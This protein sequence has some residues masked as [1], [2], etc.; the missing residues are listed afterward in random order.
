MIHA[1]AKAAKSIKSVV[2]CS[3]ENAMT[4]VFTNYFTY[5]VT[6]NSN[7]KYYSNDF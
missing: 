7:L 3:E 1:P 6:F 2:G 4:N 5:E